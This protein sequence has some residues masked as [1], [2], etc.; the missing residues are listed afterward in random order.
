MEL[1]MIICQNVPEVIWNAFRLANMMLEEM[2]DVSIFLNG[3]SVK[4]QDLDSEQFPL[5]ELAK[6]FTLSEGRL[7]A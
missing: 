3:P 2:D 1:T 4:Y 5:N 7:F 6:I